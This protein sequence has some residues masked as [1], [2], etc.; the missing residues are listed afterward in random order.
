MATRQTVTACFLG[1]SASGAVLLA[2]TA[3]LLLRAPVADGLPLLATFEGGVLVA[4]A[5]AVGL[6]VW[7]SAQHWRVGDPAR[8]LVYALVLPSLAL[9][10]LLTYGLLPAR[11]G[12]LRLGRG[13]DWWTVVRLGY[14]P[15][16]LMVSVVGLRGFHLAT[17]R[18]AMRPLIAYAFAVVLSLVVSFDGVVLLFCATI[19]LP[20]IPLM[21]VMAPIARR[22]RIALDRATDELPRAVAQR[23]V[24]G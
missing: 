5:L 8:W 15:L 18:P 11:M 23:S 4:L 1:V 7:R 17:A 22:A 9:A 16:I 12:L 24:A 10:G 14:L 6:A 3:W 19:Y 2:G 13:D 20:T 21:Y